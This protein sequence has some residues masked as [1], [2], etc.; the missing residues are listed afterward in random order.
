MKYEKVVWLITGVLITTGKNPAWQLRVNEQAD[1]VAFTTTC[2]LF[3]TAILSNFVGN[4]VWENRPTEKKLSVF[5]VKTVFL[6]FN[7]QF[8]FAMV[9]IVIFAYSWY[10]DCL[11]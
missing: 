10:Y 7:C 11:R 2:K 6:K 9:S 1:L 4:H 3:G 5:Y 8:V